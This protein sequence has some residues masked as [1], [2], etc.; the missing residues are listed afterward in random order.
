[1]SVSPT[2]VGPWSKAPVP[3]PLLPTERR[4]RR[5][6]SDGPR[7]VSCPENDDNRKDETFSVYGF[8][9]TLQK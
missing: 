8:S 3:C 1:M 9:W 2:R 6:T 5:V 7:D 4:R